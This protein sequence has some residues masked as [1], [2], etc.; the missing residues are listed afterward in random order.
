MKKITF[1]LFLFAM[2]CIEGFGQNTDRFSVIIDSVKIE[3]DKDNIDSKALILNV[4]IKNIS[5]QP[6]F[7]IS[8]SSFHHLQFD[9]GWNLI[10]KKNDVPVSWMP[11]MNYVTY[12]PSE[13]KLKK[14][15][16]KQLKM[17][18]LIT[19]MMLDINDI[20]S[21]YGTY[22]VQLAISNVAGKGKENEVSTQTVESN[23]IEF[24]I[25][26]STIVVK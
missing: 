9:A 20:K 11:N 18:T 17:A 25:D 1:L 22:T 16:E 10:L 13:F 19:D 6:L 8:P 24:D 4:K 2:I 23:I 3:I 7:F 26:E 21:L 12:Y 14:N 5:S 15:R